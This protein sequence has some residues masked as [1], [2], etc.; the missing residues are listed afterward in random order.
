[1]LLL[2]GKRKKKDTVSFWMALS[3]FFTCLVFHATHRQS[4]YNTIP[5][6]TEDYAI[7]SLDVTH[8]ARVTCCRLLRTCKFTQFSLSTHFKIWTARTQ[9]PLFFLLSVEKMRQYVITAIKTLT[10]HPASASADPSS[11][12]CV[13]R[14]VVGEEDGG[15]RWKEK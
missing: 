4:G 6:S 15:V 1:M 5:I 12:V 3:I 9:F 11:T 13:F 10:Q 14:E 2:G 8:R 7:G